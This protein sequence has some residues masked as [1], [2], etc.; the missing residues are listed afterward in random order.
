MTAAAGSN[1]VIPPVEGRRRPTARGPREAPSP[2]PDELVRG[3][4][5]YLGTGVGWRLAVPDRA[6]RCL[7]VSPAPP[8]ALEKQA[9]LCLVAEHESCATF[10]AARDAVEP[11]GDDRGGGRRP[12]R[13]SVPRTQAT[14]LDVGRGSV[15]LAALARERTTAQ[16]GLVLLALL[17][18]GAL[19]LARLVGPTPGSSAGG[20]G[21][22]LPVVASAPLATTATSAGVVVP[23]P[24]VAPSPTPAKT[25]SPSPSPRPTPSPTPSPTRARP[26]SSATPA[27][28]PVAS[29]RLY[30]VRPGDTLSAIAARFGTT[31]TA[32]EDLNG[33]TDPTRLQIGQ[34]LRIPS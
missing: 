14:V 13:W 33:I 7:A 18:F 6:H 4:C 17:A 15:D 24:T 11:P 5:P 23:P 21:A 22:S 9:R 16:V 3:I 1:P 27:P 32:L 34:V 29:Y 19:V 25:V 20:G 2:L 8:L 26:P 31:V 28:T 12:R 10:R 30:T